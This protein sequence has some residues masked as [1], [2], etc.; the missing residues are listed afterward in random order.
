MSTPAPQKTPHVHE[1][2]SYWK[3]PCLRQRI[4]MVA[5]WQ[6]LRNDEHFNVVGLQHNQTKQY[7]S[8]WKRWKEVKSIC[9]ARSQSL[10][11]Q[12][13]G[14]KQCVLTL[15]LCCFSINTIKG[16]SNFSQRPSYLYL[17]T[18]GASQHRAHQTTSD[19]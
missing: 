8:I 18:L 17:R 12:P 9:W 16:L 3:L 10:R 14:G 4:Y 7:Q 5:K 15:G 19:P 2:C 11:S 1:S 6:K 13:G